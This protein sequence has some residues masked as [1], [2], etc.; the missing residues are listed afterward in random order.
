MTDLTTRAGRSEEVTVPTN[1]RDRVGSVLTAVL[2]GP[3]GVRTSVG[4][5]PGKGPGKDTPVPLD[6][7]GVDPGLYRLR[8]CG[9]H[10]IVF[11]RDGETYTV[12]V[13]PGCT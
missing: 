3:R 11:P 9:P 5:A 4:T 7:D 6:L 1:M 10:G 2:V 12:E 8:V 13:L